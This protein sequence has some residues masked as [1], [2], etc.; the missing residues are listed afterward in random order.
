MII[1]YIDDFLIFS[2]EKKEICEL[3]SIMIKMKEYGIFLNLEKLQCNFNFLEEYTNLFGLSINNLSIIPQNYVTW[4]GLKIL[5]NDFAVK[6]FFRINNMKHSFLINKFIPLNHNIYKIYLQCERRIYKVF[7]YKENIKV[8]ENIYDFFYCFFIKLFYLLSEFDFFK[9]KK[10]NV[11]EKDCLIYKIGNLNY[12]ALK[13]K[14]KKIL[15]NNF[16]ENEKE[17][18]NNKK[19]IS[20]ESSF[21][22][23]TESSFINEITE[24]ISK[25]FHFKLKKINENISFN[26]VRKIAFNSKND[27]FNILI[28]KKLPQMKYKIILK[29]EFKNIL[30]VAAEQTFEIKTR[31][32]ACRAESKKEMIV[33]A[34]SVVKKE[35]GTHN[36]IFHCWSCKRELTV[37]IYPPKNK[38]FEV[39][40]TQSNTDIEVSLP[41]ALIEG[42]NY[43]LSEVFLSGCELISLNVPVLRIIDIN[44]FYY[45]MKCNSSDNNFI[46]DFGNS[47]SSIVNYSIDYELTK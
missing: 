1:R 7:Y 26:F 27:C 39:T 14:H 20:K 3:F 30:A 44:N 34:D 23:N 18:F 37:N 36:L 28:F 9:G 4:A 13:S 40:S 47:F 38:D 16:S 10:Y 42:L 12:K 41:V 35:V 8:N 24:E 43:K 6:C 45:E 29:G 5:S 17:N 15:P 25:V 33:T 31:C 22:S 32:A 46:G 11:N 2:R 21:I 19:E